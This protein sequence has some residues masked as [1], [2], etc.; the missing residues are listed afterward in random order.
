[1]NFKLLSTTKTKRKKKERQDFSYRSLGLFVIRHLECLRGVVCKRRVIVEAF[2][3]IRNAVSLESPELA[4]LMFH[5][6]RD[7]FALFTRETSQN[8]LRNLTM[9]SPVMLSFKLWHQGSLR[10]CQPLKF[11]SSSAG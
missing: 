9:D 5:V 8:L 11:Y 1:M 10:S 4:S 2:R 3:L 6:S 7:N